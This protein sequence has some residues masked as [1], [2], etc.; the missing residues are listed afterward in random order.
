MV[1][2]KVAGLGDRNMKEGALQP[3]GFVP[4]GSCREL[5]GLGRVIMSRYGRGVWLVFLRFFSLAPLDLLYIRGCI[6]CIYCG[7]QPSA[8]RWSLYVYLIRPRRLEHTGFHALFRDAAPSA[9]L[10]DEADGG[11]GWAWRCTDRKGETFGRC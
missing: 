3:F 5:V 6:S 10:I 4:L 2:Q 1:F 7:R 11:H 8:C 9:V